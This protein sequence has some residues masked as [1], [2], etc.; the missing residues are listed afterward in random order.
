MNLAVTIEVDGRRRSFSGEGDGAVIV[1][2][3]R[4]WLA[5]D[6]CAT[7][8][9]EADAVDREAA[10]L[11]PPAESAPHPAPAAPAR[12]TATSPLAWLRATLSDQFASG[13]T[14][15]FPDLY[16]AAKNRAPDAQTFAELTVEQFRKVL[17]QMARDGLVGV[18]T[19]GLE[20][21]YRR[22]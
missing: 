7:D 11:Q 4:T 19:V 21:V 9:P 10:R 16:Q 20:R 17:D 15:T 12:P 5:S 3:F 18:M 1:A 8:A 22:K 14:F 6:D 13:Q 2:A